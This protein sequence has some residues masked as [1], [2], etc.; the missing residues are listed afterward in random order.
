MK[1]RRKGLA[2]AGKRK[3]HRKEE[4]GDENRDETSTETHGT[5]KGRGTTENEA[6]KYP[7]FLGGVGDS[8][9]GISDL[10]VP[11][12]LL[13]PHGFTEYPLDTSGRAPYP[14]S[15]CRSVA[16]YRF[17]GVVAV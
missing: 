10:C 2:E 12:F 9:R 16:V 17:V 11:R 6:N 8:N 7:P 3:K 1:S 5:E 15:L 14:P 13:F 4:E